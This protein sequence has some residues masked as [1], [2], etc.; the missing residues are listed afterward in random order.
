MQNIDG[1]SISAWLYTVDGPAP[2]IIMSHGVGAS[3]FF[4]FARLIRKEAQSEKI[5]SA[6]PDGLRSKVELVTAP[7]LAEKG[8]FDEI[9]KG[10]TYIIHIASP[11]GVAVS[12]SY[13]GRMTK[14]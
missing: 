7:E 8:A 13:P 10:A 1:T 12:H 11:M 5:Q 6:L 3:L 2:A 14:A 4:S 9:A